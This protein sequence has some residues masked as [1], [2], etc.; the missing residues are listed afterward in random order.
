MVDIPIF[1]LALL[2]K[3][4]FTGPARA[5]T[6][7][8]FV[9]IYPLANTTLSA[10]LILAPG[11]F[12]NVVVYVKVPSELIVVEPTVTDPS[13]VEVTNKLRDEGY[14]LCQFV[15]VPLKTADWY[16]NTWLGTV[17]IL[18]NTTWGPTRNDEINCFTLGGLIV[19]GFLSEIYKL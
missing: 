5:V 19:L 1:A 7:T 17:V 16:V 11:N 10:N 18:A 6:V 8:A 15:N 3:T 4:A 2:V 13:Y 14:I 12:V 9:L